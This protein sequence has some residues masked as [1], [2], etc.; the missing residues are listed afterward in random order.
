MW[1][2][3]VIIGKN[4]EENL[5]RLKASI[6]KVRKVVNKTIYIDSASSDKSVNTA[7]VFCD[8]VI[9]LKEDKNLCASLGRRIGATHAEKDWIL[10]LDAD[11]EI[12][13]QFQ[14]WIIAFNQET[15]NSGFVGKYKDIDESRQKTRYRIFKSKKGIARY[16][17]GAVL[18]KKEALLKS[19]NWAS[20]IFSNEEIELYSRMIKKGYKV[21]SL[22]EVMVNHYTEVSTIQEDLV[23]IILVKNKK[24]TVGSSQVLIKSIKEKF[25]IALFSLQP[26]PYILFVISLVTIAFAVF[27]LKIAITWFLLSHFLLIIILRSFKAVVLGY[28]FQYLLFT[29]L[30]LQLPGSNKWKMKY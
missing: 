26:L 28:L 29:G 16:F 14:E 24:N 13:N 22:K 10:F 3:I 17:G 15:N 7:K 12:T 4:E 25:F 2:D 1:L 6:E 30:I 18:L 27:N 5:K 23:D 21:E 9:E 11:M 8:V 20:I 19:G